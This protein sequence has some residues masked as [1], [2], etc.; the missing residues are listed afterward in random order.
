MT[1]SE[2]EGNGHRFAIWTGLLDENLYVL[3]VGA[4]DS[5]GK[6]VGKL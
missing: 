5:P 1:C 3:E 6:T 2:V 4:L